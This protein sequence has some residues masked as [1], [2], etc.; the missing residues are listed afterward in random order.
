MKVAVIQMRSGIDID[1]NL[2]AATDLITAA[3]ADGATLIATPEMTHLLQRSPKKL[4]AHITHE[5]EDRGLAHFQAL[6][7]SLGVNLL[8][9]SLA[10]KVSEDRA[11]N[12]SFV[13]GPD[14]TI[15]A[16]YDKIHLFDVTLSRAE[17]YKE[18]HVYRRGD[19]AV[20]VKVDDA[21]L[22]LSVCYDVRF[23]ELYRDYAHAGA[24]IIS[25][26]AAFTRPTGQAHWATLLTSR[27]IETG[28]FIL[29]PA[30]GGT[31]DDGRA[32]WGR[33]MIIGPWGDVRAQIDNDE[34]GYVCATLDMDD[35]SL[36]RRKVPAWQHR[37]D[38]TKPGAL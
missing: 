9:G 10:I 6:A 17:T 19:K 35:V 24:Q 16:R 33:S 20:T 38:Y 27:A 2:R 34:P 32:T 1:A 4:F 12:R 3:A 21:L 23:P 28:S 14:G 29:A 18:S 31:H 26:P 37:P 36:A 30:Q 13:I 25:V 22:G 8:I 15:M 11:A 7:R 5:D